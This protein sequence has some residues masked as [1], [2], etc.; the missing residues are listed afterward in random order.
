MAVR[1]V[2]RLRIL[3][4]PVYIGAAWFIVRPETSVG[5]AIIVVLV[6]SFYAVE[7]AYDQA[8]RRDLDNARAE[9]AAAER[10]RAEACRRQVALAALRELERGDD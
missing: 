2:V 9:A 8:H 4:A 3:L 6:A 1:N 7:W 10:Q 5:Y